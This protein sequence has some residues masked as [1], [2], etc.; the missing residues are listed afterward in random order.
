MTLGID[1]CKYTPKSPLCEHVD[2][3]LYLVAIM[4]L[5][6]AAYKPAGVNKP[7]HKTNRIMERMIEFMTSQVSLPTW[8]LAVWCVFFIVVATVSIVYEYKYGK[9][10]RKIKDDNLWFEAV[11]E[12]FRNDRSKDLAVI[13]ELHSMVEQAKSERN[14]FYEGQIR[15]LNKR[16]KKAT[17]DNRVLSLHYAVMAGGSTDDITKA[18]KVFHRHLQGKE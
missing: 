2:I 15:G 8:A 6:F 17:D 10:K 11:V 1:G 7:R 9:A 16:I 18:A 5:I 13:K 14:E 12:N 4:L 3:F